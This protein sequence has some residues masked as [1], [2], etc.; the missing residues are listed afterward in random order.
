MATP[1]GALVADNRPVSDSG[2]ALLLQDLPDIDAVVSLDQNWEIEVSSSSPYVIAR[3]KDATVNDECGNA[4]VSATFAL[5]YEAAQKGLD[6]FS[7]TG[8]P[9]LAVRETINE[10]LV[11]WREG[12]RQVLRAI[13][14]SLSLALS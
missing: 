2:V 1:A 12:G 8:T 9:D 11:W 7:V 10:S 4:N 3:G 6:L 13:G 5:A 14:P